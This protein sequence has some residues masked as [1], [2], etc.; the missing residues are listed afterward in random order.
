MSRVLHPLVNNYHGILIEVVQILRF[1]VMV[2]NR[3]LVTI[4]L[5]TPKRQ[6][7]QLYSYISILK[8]FTQILYL[9]AIEILQEYLNINDILFKI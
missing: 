9:R 5:I 7:A 3:P 2:L 8:I 4:F 6:L 1:F